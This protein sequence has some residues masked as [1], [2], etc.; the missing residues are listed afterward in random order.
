MAKSPKRFVKKP[1]GHEE[2][3]AHTEKY[4][5]KF[6][7]IEPGE[8]LSRQYHR[9]KEETIYVL[10]GNLRVEIGDPNAGGVTT[11]VLDPG[12]TV[13]VTP[14]LVHRFCADKERVKLVEVSTP[15]LD[16]VVRLEDKYVRGKGK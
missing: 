2:I 12:K 13:H 3:W 16:D 9:I 4:V 1:W 15:E 10:E 6:L 7:V 5:G 8:M 11:A 14:L